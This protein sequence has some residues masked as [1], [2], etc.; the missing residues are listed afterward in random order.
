MR[1]DFER[2]KRALME[3]TSLHLFGGGI[4]KIMKA[5]VKL[6]TAQMYSKLTPLEYK[7]RASPLHKLTRLKLKESNHFRAQ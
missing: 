3:A 7:S 2:N 4:W 5:S 1:Q 6:A